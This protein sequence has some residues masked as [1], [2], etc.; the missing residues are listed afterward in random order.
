V[1]T[2]LKPALILSKKELFNQSFNLLK[3]QWQ[4]QSLEKSNSYNNNNNNNKTSF[5]LSQ[6]KD[7]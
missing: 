5:F 2:R 4:R 3:R 6:K 7:N 1:A